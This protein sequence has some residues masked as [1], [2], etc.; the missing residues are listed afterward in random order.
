MR[1]QIASHKTIFKTHFLSHQTYWRSTKS[2][3]CWIHKHLNVLNNP[4]NRIINKETKKKNKKNFTYFNWGCI[5]LLIRKWQFCTF[6]LC[7]N[8]THTHTS[9]LILWEVFTYSL[10]YKKKWASVVEFIDCLHMYLLGGRKS[11]IFVIV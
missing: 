2:R 3:L 4:T 5:T 9:S 8:N 11:S 6:I 7:V 1:I 10:N